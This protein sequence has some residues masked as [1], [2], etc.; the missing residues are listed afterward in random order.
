MKT[1][2][3]K[4]VSTPKRRSH[5]ALYGHRRRLP[6]FGLSTRDDSKRALGELHIVRGGSL[7]TERGQAKGLFQRVGLR[8]GQVRCTLRELIKDSGRS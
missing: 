2:N 8:E 4:K 1:R 3:T 5:Q 7:D 6:C